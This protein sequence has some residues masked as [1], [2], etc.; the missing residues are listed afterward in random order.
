MRFEVAAKFDV[1]VIGS[2]IS[3][4]ISALELAKGNKSVCILTKEAVTESS[5][6]YAQGGIAVPLSEGD[7]VEAHL[8][9]TIKAGAGLCN[10]DA[11]KEIISNSRIALEKLISYGVCFDQSSRNI[12]HQTKEAAHSKPRVCHVGGDAS[13]RFITKTLID[14]ASREPNISISQGSVVLSL[15]KNDNGK[16]YG[17]LVEDVTQS[18]YVILAKD[19]IIA[20]GGIGQLFETTTNPKVCSG[21]GV[22][23]AYRA[24]AFLQDIEMIQFHPTVLLKAGVPFLITEAIRGEGGKLKNINGEYFA[25]TYHEL[26]ELAPRDVLS[27][28]IS[29]EMKK[30]KSDHVLLDTNNFDINYF[31]DR[32]PTVYKT[33]LERKI[34]FADIPVCPAVHY[35]VGG[36]KCDIYGCTNIDSLWVIGEAASNGFH[37]ANRLASNSLL[38]CIVVPHFLAKKL[39]SK[40]SSALPE[41]DFVDIEVSNEPADDKE[42][43]EMT[44]MLKLSNSK[45]LGLIR[46]ETLLNENINCLNKIGER[47]N[48]QLVSKNNNLQELKNM[49]LLSGLISFVA[50]NRKYSL[51]VH[52]REDCT[53]TP[54]ELT[55]SVISLNTQLSCEKHTTLPQLV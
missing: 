52:F 39:L 45:N 9:D 46:K 26:A 10:Q 40:E 53:K 14:K 54:L 27:R 41:L 3:G 8:E 5:S 25:S 49:I 17:V 33:C 15:L 36:I 37:G 43:N 31:K 34:N 13:G 18:R 51:G 22:V 19:I 29:E 11:A 21:D 42:I 38:E 20:S 1:V 35:F 44:N 50:L 16:I 12:L 24:G 4:L 23:M 47:F 48:M 28:A 6:L 55:H 7:T 2:G 30:T 32:F